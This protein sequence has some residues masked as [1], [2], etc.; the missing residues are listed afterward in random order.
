VVNNHELK[1]KRRQ[2]SGAMKRWWKNKEILWFALKLFYE[3][4]HDRFEV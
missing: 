4:R 3:D 1:T 2:S